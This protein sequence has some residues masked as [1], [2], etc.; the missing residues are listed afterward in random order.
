MNPKTIEIAVRI[1]KGDLQK[2]VPVR[3]KMIDF[4][5]AQDGVGEDAEFESF[6]ALPVPDEKPVFIGMTEYEDLATTSK[7]QTKLLFGGFGI[8][9]NA[10]KFFTAIDMKAYYFMKQIEGETFDLAKVASKKGQVLE[11]AIREV[12]D[13]NLEEFNRLRK[14]FVANLSKKPG[15][16]ESYEFRPE[17]GKNKDKVWIGMS[18]YDSKETLM[19]I[20]DEVMGEELTQNYFKT[21]KPIATQYTVRTVNH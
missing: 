5:I 4:L 7:V 15:V 2:F 1:I 12:E 9:W 17:K 10:I 8:L 20:T 18:V 16:L 11:I 3:K 13:E 19:K 6:H 14:E 21:F